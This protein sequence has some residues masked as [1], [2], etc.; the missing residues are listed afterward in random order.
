MIG[1]SKCGRSKVCY[2]LYKFAVHSLTNTYYSPIGSSRSAYKTIW[3]AE[4]LAGFLPRAIREEAREERMDVHPSGFLNSCLVI[5]S[6][7]S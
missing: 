2:L 6:L 7:L 3:M 1:G 4:K 5:I